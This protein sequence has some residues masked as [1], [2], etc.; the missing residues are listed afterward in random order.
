[1]KRYVLAGIAALVITVLVVP[2]LLVFLY[3]GTEKAKPVEAF[4]EILTTAKKI[5]ETGTSQE[6][7]AV[8]YTV[9]VYRN[10]LKKVQQ[11]ELEDYIVGVV[12]AEMPAEFEL[13]ALK[14]QAMAARTFLVQRIATGDFHDVPVGAQVIDTVKN[15]V[16]LD[17][18]QRRETW[19]GAYEMKEKKV[20]QAVKETAGDILTYNN[21]PIMASFFS[22][23]NGYTE[24]AEDYWGGEKIPYLR[25]VAVPW[26]KSS[27]KYTASVSM[28]LSQFEKKLNT[29]VTRTALAQSGENPQWMKILSYTQGKR[30]E[31]AKIGTK[32]YTGREVREKLGLNSSQFTMTYKNNSVVI[33][34][35]GYGHG[36]G[37]SQ[38]GA[39]GMAQQ[40][41]T[42]EEI[43]KYFYKDIEVENAAK[44]L[45]SKK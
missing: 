7:K 8:P 1:M 38:F 11:V 21:K 18:Q 45:P 30:V 36:V 16:Y 32:S 24:N 41:K 15:Q 9:K 10:D 25:S 4:Q 42:A 28:S 29:R 5:G 34:T 40:G 43:V 3:P 37:M 22:T 14:A 35:V 23:S 17:E 20:E 27:P 26:D 2:T 44:Y 13:E 19:G 6:K 31:Q 33:K 39:N 12:A